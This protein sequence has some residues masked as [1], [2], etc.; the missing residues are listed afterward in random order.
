MILLNMQ[1]RTS[2]V[3]HTETQVNNHR[4]SLIC[5]SSLLTAILIHYKLSQGLDI[6]YF[7]KQRKQ[8]EI[9]SQHWDPH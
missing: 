3:I 5:L 8:D 7:K 9:D 1:I 6:Q 4:K 2:S